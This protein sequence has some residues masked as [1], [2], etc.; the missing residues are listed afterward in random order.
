MSARAEA[1]MADGHDRH[2]DVIW[3]L[4]QIA[5]SRNFKSA[6]AEAGRLTATTATRALATIL[7]GGGDGC[8][9]NAATSADN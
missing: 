9:S 2:Q 8:L 1:G 6:R 5:S 4:R 3:D 7:R